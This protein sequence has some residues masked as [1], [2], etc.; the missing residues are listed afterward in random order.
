M[1]GSRL[2]LLYWVFELLQICLHSVR[3]FA[4]EIA[5]YTFVARSY[6]EIYSVLRLVFQTGS[7]AGQRRTV[8]VGLFPP[9]WMQRWL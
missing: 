6:P 7:I 1:K 8:F 3:I 4:I 5:L 2:I 9:L